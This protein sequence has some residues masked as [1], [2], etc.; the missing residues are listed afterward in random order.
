[1]ETNTPNKEPYE[2]LMKKL[3]EAYRNGLKPFKVGQKR[4]LY[5]DRAEDDV[6]LAHILHVL[7]HPEDAGEQLIVYRWF[8]KH[9]RHWWY[10]VTETWKQDLWEAYCQDVVNHKKEKRK[11]KL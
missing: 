6:C 9:K 11:R 10:G 2:L 4:Y 7:P 5:D 1:M 3:P 8:G